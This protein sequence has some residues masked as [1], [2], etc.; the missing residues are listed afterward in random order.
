[1]DDLLRLADRRITRGLTAAEREKY[2]HEPLK[3]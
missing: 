3:R 2:L 1:L